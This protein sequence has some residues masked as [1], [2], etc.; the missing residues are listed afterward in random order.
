MNVTVYL[1][2]GGNR[3]ELRTKCRRGFSDF[4]RKAGLAGRM[5]KLVACGARRMAYDGFRAA[6]DRSGEIFV[7]LLVDSEEPVTENA[8]S[9]DHLSRR[10]NWGKPTRAADDNAHLMV[11]CMEAWFLADKDALV[12]YF[13]DGFNRKALPAQ[14]NVE[15][16]PKTDIERG[17]KSATRQCTTKGRYNKGRHSFALLAQI[18]P[19]KVTTASPHAKRLI[20]TLVDKTSE[21]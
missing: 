17:L 4:F 3:R 18:S 12:E 11:Q 5:P 9:W 21:H 2:G 6:F 20:E 1:E 19:E 8:G 13:G 14:A 15:D 7:V 10:D 16:I